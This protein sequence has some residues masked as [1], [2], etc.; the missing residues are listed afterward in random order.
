M[1]KENKF[2]AM[3]VS[4]I[5]ICLLIPFFLQ[6]FVEIKETKL[7]GDIPVTSNIT[8]TTETWFSGAYA[9]I[10]TL[11]FN[12]NFT[13]HNAA[14]RLKNQINFSLF[15][16]PGARDVVVGKNGYLYEE[17][18]IKAYTGQDYIGDTKIDRLYKEIKFIQD[19]LEKKGITFAILYAPGKASF[20]PEFIPSLYG[21]KSMR[22][23]YTEGIKRAERLHINYIDFNQLFVKL[24]HKCPYPLYGQTGTHWSVYGMYLAFDTLSK[25]IA[26]KSHKELSHII[27][28]KVTVS[29]T[30][31]NT[32]GDL[33]SG[34]NVFLE[35]KHYA[36]AYPDAHW[37]YPK[38]YFRPS[39][40][41]VSD[42]YWMGLYFL[43]LPKNAFSNHE[44]WYYNT[45]LYNYDKNGNVGNVVD[46]DLKNTI[47]RNNFIFIMATEASLG[48]MGWGFIHEVYS[49]YKN[50]PVEYEKF[51]VKKKKEAELTTIVLYIEKDE[52]WLISIRENAKALKI[53]VDSCIAMNAE[54]IYN[55][56]HK[57]DPK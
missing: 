14:I 9:N 23:N 49:L 45:Q 53:S 37:E 40:L 55:E 39:V 15:N 35:P 11:Y 27:Y 8:L 44:F 47:E 33:E 17:K 57:N 50:G 43:N 20:Y 48:Q 21:E 52:N 6:Y 10:K 4:C 5:I 7:Y 30:L 3:Q 24:K 54:Y 16:K 12:D 29:D 32:D 25:F 56:R 26:N 46:A 42:S 19:T 13:F 36:M 41:T 28:D 18:Y 1:A 34:L 38:N 22:T 2:Y 31:R 51:K